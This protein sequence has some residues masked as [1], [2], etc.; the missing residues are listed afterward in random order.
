MPR[1]PVRDPSDDA[2]PG[3]QRSVMLHHPSTHSLKRGG[4]SQ[5]PPIARDDPRVP[6]C[7]VF[8]RSPLCLEIDV[9]QPESFL[10][11]LLPLEV[12]QNRPMKVAADVAAVGD[13]AAEG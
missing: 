6:V 8:E 9:D 2:I 3:T 1:Q 7:R 12:V 5:A 13:R 10:V 4:F 11:A